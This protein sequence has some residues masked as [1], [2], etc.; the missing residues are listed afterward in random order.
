MLAGLVTSLEM[1]RGCKGEMYW[2]GI[3]PG[4]VFPSPGTLL[5]SRY[6]TLDVAKQTMHMLVQNLHVVRHAVVSYKHCQPID[7][8]CSVFA[9]QT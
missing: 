1:S 3:L 8:G 6:G 4:G 2:Q 7:G 5:C 9:S